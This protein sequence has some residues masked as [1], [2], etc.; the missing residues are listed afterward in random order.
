MNCYERGMIMM[1][2]FSSSNRR[3][4][5]ILSSTSLNEV[6]DTVIVTPL[7]TN[8]VN[9]A[10]PLR[11]NLSARGGMPKATDIM[12]EL[13]Y[14]VAKDKIEQTPISSLSD[15]EMSSVVGQIS[16]IIS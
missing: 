13:I 11:F 2:N 7:T 9:D 16:K 15:D 12:L 4:C 1:V 5:L 14:T 6:L 8:V 3:P 10:W